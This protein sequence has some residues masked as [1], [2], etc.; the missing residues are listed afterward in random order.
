[1]WGKENKKQQSI[2]KMKERKQHVIIKS[3][4]KKVWE[5]RNN[6]TTNKGN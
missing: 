1:M 3:R 2:W 6:S 5:Q 4:S